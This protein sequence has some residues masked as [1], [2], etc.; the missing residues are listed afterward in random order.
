MKQRRRDEEKG[1]KS[2]SFPNRQ[3]EKF[4]RLDKGVKEEDVCVYM[5]E[6]G[7]G[8]KTLCVCI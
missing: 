1:S 7:R 2:V 3:S 5:R 8:C 4:R 6:V